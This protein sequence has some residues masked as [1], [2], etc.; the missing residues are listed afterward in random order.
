MALDAQKWEN[1]HCSHPDR[2]V[3]ALLIHPVRWVFSIAI[4]VPPT[5]IRVLWHIEWARR[6]VDADDGVVYL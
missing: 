6:T 4:S 5:R 3:Q 1:I 2:G